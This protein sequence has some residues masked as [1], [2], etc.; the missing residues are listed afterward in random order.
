MLTMHEE[1]Y[2]EWFKRVWND[3]LALHAAYMHCQAA[4]GTA[5]AA[6]LLVKAGCRAAST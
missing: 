6:R 1:A 3:P 2:I 4:Q 5:N